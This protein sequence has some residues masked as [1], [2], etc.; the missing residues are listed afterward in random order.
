MHVWRLAKRKYSLLDGEGA[1][2]FGGRWNSKGKAVVYTAHSLSL[3]LLEQF[4]RIDPDNLPED[5]A[6]FKIEIPDTIST[7]TIEYNQFP[8]DWRNV[9]RST[10]FKEQGDTWLDKLES[11]VLIVPSVIIPQEN[12]YLINPL[13]SDSKK[14]KIKEINDFSL[15]LRL[16]RK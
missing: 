14:I 4:V 13:H 16:F 9:E 15:D 5:F 2:L 8:K 1:R 12:H 3:G 11:A 7:K 10:W 6:S